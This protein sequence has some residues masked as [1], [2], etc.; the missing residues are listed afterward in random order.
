MQ[1]IQHLNKKVGNSKIGND[2]RCDNQIEN[3][4]LNAV[5][6]HISFGDI[7]KGEVG[8]TFVRNQV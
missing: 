2:G 1:V 5:H 7:V 3:G 8:V 6:V 4:R